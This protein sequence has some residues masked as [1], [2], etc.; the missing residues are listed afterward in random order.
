MVINI[1]IFNFHYSTSKIGSDESLP[2]LFTRI[3]FGF[4]INISIGGEPSNVVAAVFF[5]PPIKTILQS[6]G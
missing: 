1:I 3:V 2:A 6:S 5:E 4:V